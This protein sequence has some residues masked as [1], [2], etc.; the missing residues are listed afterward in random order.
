[1]RRR[2][3]PIQTMRNAKGAFL[4]GSKKIPDDNLDLQKR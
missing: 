2:F 3:Q 1:M 4:G